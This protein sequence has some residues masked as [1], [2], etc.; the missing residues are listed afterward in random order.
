MRK[1]VCA[2]LIATTLF[3]NC[4]NVSFAITEAPNKKPLQAAPNAKTIEL[5]FVFDGPSDKNAEVLKI[6][7]Q[8]E[9]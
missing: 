9:A 7:Q 2:F 4:A 5:A 8:T 3:I 6:F 1:T